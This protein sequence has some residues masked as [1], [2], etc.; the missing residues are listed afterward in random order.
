MEE[1]Y[2]DFLG[3]PITKKEYEERMR[4]RKK[5]KAKRK[6][7]KKE[8]LS[9]T[10]HDDG[11]DREQK[12]KNFFKKDNYEDSGKVF[13]YKKGEYKAKIKEINPMAKIDDNA[14]MTELLD[15]LKKQED[16][17]KQ[18]TKKYGRPKKKGELEAFKGALATK[19]K[20]GATDYRKG[21]LFLSIVNNRK[22]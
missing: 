11:P 20:I 18:E 12:L 17:K 4:K 6:A 9:K 16:K 1:Q 10:F 19:K 15:A 3:F 22:K 2:R 21:G 14:T 8:R 5:R 13:N 7:E